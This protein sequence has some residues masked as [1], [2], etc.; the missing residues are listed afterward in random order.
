MQSE[1]F[2]SP[3]FQL[4]ESWVFIF[5]RYAPRVGLLS[6]AWEILQ[7]PLYTLWNEKPWGWIVLSALHCSAGDIL[8]GVLSLITAL[9]ICRAGKPHQ[10]PRTKLLLICILVSI[11]YTIFS[12]QINLVNASWAYSLWMPIVPYLNIG[13]SPLLQWVVVPITAWRWANMNPVP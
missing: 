11:I 1:Y 10:W 5:R 7:L 4:R 6:L 3:W 2:N 12:E 8:I 13:L 9:V